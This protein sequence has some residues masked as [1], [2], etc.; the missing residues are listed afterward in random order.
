RLIVPSPQATKLYQTVLLTPTPPTSQLS[1]GSATV[2]FAPTVQYGVGANAVAFSGIGDG[3]AQ[4]SFG[5]NTVGVNEKLKSSVPPSGL[6]KS[7]ALMRYVVPAT[8][9]TLT[10]CE[11]R[12][13]PLSSSH[14]SSAGD[15]QVP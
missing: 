5:G 4:L 13:V 11:L 2:A 1:C 10:S 14:A 6:P 8:T 3:P 15:A 9:G 12:P 7:A